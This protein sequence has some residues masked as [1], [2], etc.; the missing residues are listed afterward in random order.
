LDTTVAI[1]HFF[2]R[3]TRQWQVDVEKRKSALEME[4]MQL[5]CRKSRGKLLNTNKS[6]SECD[7][8]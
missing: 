1:T 4:R 2:D 3:G 7:L 5:L 8:L 6:F